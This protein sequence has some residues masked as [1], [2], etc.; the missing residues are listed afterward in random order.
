MQNKN[1]PIIGVRYF[2]LFE[3]CV[4]GKPEQVSVSAR[5]NATNNF[6]V[7]QKLTLQLCLYAIL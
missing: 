1:Q 4:P 5:T 2:L 7:I 3:P 6:M